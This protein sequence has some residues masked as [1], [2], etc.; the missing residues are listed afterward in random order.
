MTATPI[1]ELAGTVPGPEP[2]RPAKQHS[3]Y[4]WL[5]V[6]S[7]NLLEMHQMKKSLIALAVLGAFTGSAFA[8][9]NVQLYG[10]IDAGVAHYSNGNGS[11]TK[12]GTGIQSGSRIGLKG[13]EDLGGGLSALFQAETGFCANG[14]TANG[15]ASGLAAGGYCTG[16]GFMQRTAIVG[17]KGDFGTM[18]AGRMYTLTFND[19]AAVDPF[20]YGLN[21]TISNIGTIGAPARVSQAVAYVS[22]NFSG[23]NFAGAYVFGDGLG[24]TTAT[25]THT[26]GAYNLHAGYN[27]GPLMVGLDYLRANNTAGNATVKHTMLVGTYD[28]GVAKLAGMYAQNKPDAAAG[29]GNFQAWMLGGTVPVGPGAILLSYTQAKNKDVSETTSKQVAVGYTYA[30]SKR[31]NL[32]TSYAHISNQSGVFAAVQDATGNND[33]PAGGLG[34]SSS[35]FALGIR[36]QF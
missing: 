15:A 19:Q 4:E 11:V 24:L 6:L 3:Q 1:P 22:P 14:G 33:A 32:Y 17:L 13:T 34:M 7:N 28:L 36:H 2:G 8:A 12:L 16:G 10:I 18:V 35:G 29:G 5:P 26:T 25:T 27:N 9:D 30:L 20:G 21:G 23:F 31:T